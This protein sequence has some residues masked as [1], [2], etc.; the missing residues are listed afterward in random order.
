MR[1]HVTQKGFSIITGSEDL[2]FYTF[3]CP[4]YLAH[5]ITII[6]SSDRDWK[7]CF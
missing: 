6:S 4:A 1:H 5:L 7:P 2:D 3:V